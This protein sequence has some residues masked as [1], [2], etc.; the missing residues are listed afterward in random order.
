[1]NYEQ[2]SFQKEEPFSIPKNLLLQKCSYSCKN[3]TRQKYSV[4][5]VFET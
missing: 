5:L 2:F 4:L 3:A 1:M